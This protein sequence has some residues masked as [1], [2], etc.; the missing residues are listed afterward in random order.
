M[1]SSREFGKGGRN[2]LSINNALAIGPQI[3]YY[4]CDILF[5]GHDEQEM[6]NPEASLFCGDAFQLQDVEIPA[7]VAAQTFFNVNRDR[8]SAVIRIGSIVRF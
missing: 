4:S 8:E 2:R 3:P 6:G 5:R 7:F 1:L